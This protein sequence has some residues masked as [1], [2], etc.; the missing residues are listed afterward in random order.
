L[1]VTG[2]SLVYAG[3]ASLLSVCA[4]VLPA[5][6][7]A[8]TGI[9][10]QKRQKHRRSAAPLWQKL[11]LD[12]IVL[13]VALYGLYSFN[14]QKEILAARVQDGASLD[15]LLF[16]S[17]SLFMIGCGLLA[18]RIVPLIVW[19]VY[20]LFRRWWSPAMYASFLQVLR[21]RSSQSFIMV[22]LI[23]TIALGV[24][25]AQAARTINQNAEDNLYYTIGADMVLQERWQSTETDEDELSAAT[26]TS[27]IYY[28]PDFGRYEALQG[29]QAVTK[30]YVSDD[31]S[32]S[33]AKGGNLKNVRLMGIHTKEFGEVAWFKDTLSDVH[34]YHYLNAMAQNSRA[35]LV[36]RNF[37]E[38]HGYQL[39][40]SI[41]YRNGNNDSMRGVIYGFVDYFPGFQPVSYTKGSD[42]LYT[43]TENYLI[44]A[45]L[46][47]IQSSWGI[48]PYQVWV[49]NKDSGAYLYDFAETVENGFSVF[50][51]ASASMIE[52]KN[53]PV[54]QGTNGILTVGFIVVLT[55]CSVGFLIFWILSIKSRSLLFGIFRAMGMSM[56]EVF[57]M[58]IN[59]QLFIS[60][61]SIAAGALV[62]QLTAKLY[63]PLIQLAYA[64]S[65]NAL[66]LEL[67]S[68]PSDQIRLF[69]VV[70]MVMLVC[71]FVLGALISRMKVTQALKLGED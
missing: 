4:M 30:V 68:L 17:S 64:A 9:V 12:I 57:T 38:K 31:V 3:A 8:K 10:T 13:L 47:Q 43:E 6:R 36:S 71:M 7:Y 41:T 53:D 51:D 37:A 55:L 29:A 28:E 23:M 40:D 32:L 59:E 65:D 62:G 21:S 46:Q 50:K 35:V 20:R 70:G 54:L 27:V 44:V 48:L 52:K 67:V 15:P 25:N 26:E 49:R 2:E 5:L 39:G 14:G 61:I 56:R 11:G 33:L 63:M 22:F 1:E 18:V 19:C 60:G 42:G 58:L 45:H 24:F 69:A 16:L 66:P 34:W